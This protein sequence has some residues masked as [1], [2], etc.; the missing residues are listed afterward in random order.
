MR[1]AVFLLLA[2]FSLNSVSRGNAALSGRVTS[3]DEG[4]MEGVLVSA[5]Q[6]GSSVTITVVSDAQG[7]YGFPASRLQAGTYS[8]GIRAVGYELSAPVTIAIAP[9]YSRSQIVRRPLPQDD[10]KQRQPDLTLAKKLLS[11]SPSTVLR[12][13]LVETINYFDRLLQDK[14]IRASLMIQLE[15]ASGRK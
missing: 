13:G 6:T 15:T 14:N 1:L 2:F 10:P 9:E 8:L 11:W 4:A 12:D 3:V 5:K 7:R